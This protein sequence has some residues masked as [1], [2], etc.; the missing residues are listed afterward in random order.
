[1][2]MSRVKN[3]D[4]VDGNLLTVEAKAAR[5]Y[6]EGGKGNGQAILSALSDVVPGP[7]TRVKTAK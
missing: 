4:R 1:V 6:A 5:C 7:S 2:K 3:I